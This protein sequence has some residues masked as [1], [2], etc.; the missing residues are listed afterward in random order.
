MGGAQ[1]GCRDEGG[2]F[3]LLDSWDPD[4]RINGTPSTGADIDTACPVR[5]RS[6]LILVAMPGACAAQ[7]ALADVTSSD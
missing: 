2:G 3:C 1:Q 4:D 7:F 5:T 6:Y